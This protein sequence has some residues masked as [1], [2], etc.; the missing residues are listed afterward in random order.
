MGS[1][2]WACR[3]RIGRPLPS[4]DFVDVVFLGRNEYIA[5]EV[6]SGKVDITRRMFQCI[7]YGAVLEALQASNGLAK[8]V[9]TMLILGGPLPKSLVALKNCLG[10][11]VV[12][13]LT[14]PNTI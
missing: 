11:E 4:G 5:V 7:K 2:S 3:T 1:A 6:T 8:D 14:T 13:G 9:R 12:E 10:I